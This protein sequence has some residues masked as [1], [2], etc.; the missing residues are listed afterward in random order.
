MSDENDSS[1]NENENRSSNNNS[2]N[3]IL[4]SV[5]MLSSDCSIHRESAARQQ[6]ALHIL[7]ARRIPFS[8]IRGEDPNQKEM[9]VFIYV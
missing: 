6:R 2:N 5:I 3:T 4:R 7:E 8:V 1:R 9:Q